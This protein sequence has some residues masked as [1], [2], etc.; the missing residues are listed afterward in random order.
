MP[1]SE[2]SPTRPS[3]DKKKQTNK[4]IKNK[5]GEINIRKYNRIFGKK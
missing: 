1:E 4:Q 3:T 5:N 2:D